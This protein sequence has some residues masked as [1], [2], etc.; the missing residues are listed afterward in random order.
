MARVLVHAVAALHG[1]GGGERRG[2]RGR[3][4]HG[5]LVEQ[6][7]VGH[8]AEALGQ[9]QGRSGADG[10]R[11]R[12]VEAGRL[13]AEVRGLDDQ[14]VAVPVAAR[15]AHPLGDALGQMPAPVEGHDAGV[16]HHLVQYR[17]VVGGLEHLDVLVVAGGHDG[18][19]RVEPEDAPLGEAPVL[20]AVGPDARR[21][22]PHGARAGPVFAQRQ[23]DQ[24]DAGLQRRQAARR[25]IDDERR[26]P[27]VDDP[28]VLVD[29]VAVVAADVAAHRQG[30][31]AQLAGG[32]G[33]GVRL[34][35]RRLDLAD[36]LR[37]QHRLV[38]VRGPLQRRQRL[39]VPHALQ[40][41]L[42]VGQPRGLVGLGAG[43]RRRHRHGQQ[44]RDHREASYSHLDH[45]SI[46]SFCLCVPGTAGAGRHLQ[47]SAPRSS[48][49]PANF[50]TVPADRHS[51]LRRRTSAPGRRAARRR[52]RR[53]P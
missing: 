9:V 23:L 28:G 13:V 53:R 45:S 43:R 16:V 4:V 47:F 36:L 14:G 26:P 44:G 41:G 24:L 7:V 40:I 35:R 42:A 30:L 46:C 52:P 21:P 12:R 8:P 27:V 34:G 49:A 3:V 48:A 32:V 33:L 18:R 5:V 17:H 1:Q 22:R 15:V 38:L 39:E 2:E 51:S 10:M 11:H 31:V 19:A 6:G 20:V 25:R 37:R 29:P 50:R